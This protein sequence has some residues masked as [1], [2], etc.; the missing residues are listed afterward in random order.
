[1]SVPAYGPDRSGSARKSAPTEGHGHGGW[2]MLAMLFCCI[3]MVVAVVL[4]MLGR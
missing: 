1:M 2:A 3:P 4:I